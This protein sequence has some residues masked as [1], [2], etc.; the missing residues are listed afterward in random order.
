M[1]GVSK[2][3]L[4]TTP[5]RSLSTDDDVGRMVIHRLDYSER[6]EEK[7]T[8]SVEIKLKRSLVIDFS[9]KKYIENNFRTIAISGSWFIATTPCDSDSDPDSDSAPLGVSEKNHKKV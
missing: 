7:E 1:F 8:G 5:A 6:Q 3:L 2:F 9:L 4:T